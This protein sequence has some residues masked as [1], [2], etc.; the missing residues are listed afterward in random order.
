MNININGYYTFK[1]IPVIIQNNNGKNITSGIEI[2]YLILGNNNTCKIAA[3]EKSDNR[4]INIFQLIKSFIFTN[5]EIT[6]HDSNNK[7]RTFFVNRTTLFNELSQLDNQKLLE[8]FNGY[9]KNQKQQVIQSLFDKIFIQPTLLQNRQQFTQSPPIQQSNSLYRQAPQQNIYPV[10][11]PIQQSLNISQ[12]V[13]YQPP[14]FSYSPPPIDSQTRY[15]IRDETLGE[16]TRKKIGSTNPNDRLNRRRMLDYWANATPQVLDAKT[17]YG[18]QHCILFRSSAS[19]K[20]FKGNNILGRFDV[21]QMTA[22]LDRNVFWNKTK[23]PSPPVLIHHAAGI[24]IGENTKAQDF[25]DYA[26]PDKRGVM[27]L[28]ETR[29]LNDMKQVFKSVLNAQLLSGTTDAVWFPLGM[30]AFLRRLNELDN[31]YTPQKLDVLRKKIAEQFVQSCLEVNQ[32]NTMVIHLCLS[33]VNPESSANYQAFMQALTKATLGNVHL[34]INGDAG[35]VARQ[36]ALKGKQVSLTNGAN[37]NLIGNHW[38]DNGAE[39]AIDEALCRKF[40]ELA[41]KAVILNPSTTFSGDY[42]TRLSS[43]I[44]EF[45]GTVIDV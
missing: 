13:R 1:S 27:R 12:N 23:Q 16:L 41:K 39:R 31:N 26:L 45:G 5:I 44:H 25:R 37:R 38:M 35:E 29:Y 8:K 34:H 30:G 22:P 17:V 18:M 21:L 36:L 15:Q 4:I 3:E 40:V 9:N 14:T 24:N 2:N 20:T 33:D 42:S 7:H 43:R 28:D 11:P 19:K 10:Q 6:L 32:R